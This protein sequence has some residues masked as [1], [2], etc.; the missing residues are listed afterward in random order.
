[1][2]TFLSWLVMS[3]VEPTSPFPDSRTY[4]SCAWNPGLAPD[5]PVASTRLALDL[6]WGPG[7]FVADNRSTWHESAP[8]CYP[9]WPSIAYEVKLPAHG[10]KSLARIVRLLIALFLRATCLPTFLILPRA[11]FPHSKYP[12]LWLARFCT[13]LFGFGKTLMQM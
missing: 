1:M 11:I 6:D 4:S 3:T 2:P 10:S 8:S 5:S 7:W 9:S 12:I 13:F